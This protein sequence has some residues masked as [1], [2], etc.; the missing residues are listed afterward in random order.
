MVLYHRFSIV[1]GGVPVPC[2]HSQFVISFMSIISL[3]LDNELTLCGRDEF[4]VLRYVNLYKNIKYLLTI[5]LKRNTIHLSNTVWSVW[6]MDDFEMIL[7]ESLKDPEFKKEWE[8]GQIEYEIM[9][10]LVE[11]RNEKILH[12][13]NCPNSRV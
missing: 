8:A 13:R 2:R 9:R 12:R 6:E 1:T 5:F 11:A 7:E 10:M 3:W 4:L